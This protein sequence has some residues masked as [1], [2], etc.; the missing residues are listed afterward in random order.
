MVHLIT[1][2]F[3]FSFL[4]VSIGIHILIGEICGCSYGVL[5]PIAIVALVVGVGLF[6]ITLGVQVTEDRVKCCF[7][8][9]P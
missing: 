5:F 3:L 2:G 9:I 4:L 7:H 8:F 6:G 1:L